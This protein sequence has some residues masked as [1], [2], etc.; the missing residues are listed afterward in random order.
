M[1]EIILNELE[2]TPGPA[3]PDGLLCDG[4]GEPISYNAPDFMVRRDPWNPGR[5]TKGHIHCIDSVWQPQDF[6]KD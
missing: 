6:E 3:T 1:N 4:C 5:L 2:T